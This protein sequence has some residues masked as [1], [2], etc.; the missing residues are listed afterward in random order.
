MSKNTIGVITQPTYLPWLGYFEQI[1]YSDTFV[2]LDNVQYP[3]REW[4][5]RNRILNNGE[6]MWLTVPIAKTPQNTNINKIKISYEEE[7]VK[8]HLKSIETVYHKSLQFDEVFQIVKKELE[9]T[10]EYLA[11]LNI[12]LI[13]GVCSYLGI[14][15][16]KI[17][18]SERNY[19]SKR[20]QLLADICKNYEIDYYYTSQGAKVYLDK[21][22]S[23]LENVGIDVE[24]QNYQPVAY[25]QMGSKEFVPHLSIVDL[26]FNV[27][28][29][30]AVEIIKA[31]ALH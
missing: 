17:R 16:K 4:C 2:F 12:A 18:A 29:E 11:D 8:N 5:N 21:E 23:T 28:K 19:S 15:T 7:W 13:D 27:P 24:Y 9:K 1:L 10:Y 31:G 14:K 25:N 3:R 6:I 20:T 22:I 26:L 30:K